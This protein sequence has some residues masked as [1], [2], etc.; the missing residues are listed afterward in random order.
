MIIDNFNF[1]EAT[2]WFSCTALCIAGVRFISRRYY[3][4]FI[5][6]VANIF[7]FGLTDIIEIYTGGF[8]HTAR[9]L[10]VWKIVH[11]LGLVISIIWYIKLRLNSKNI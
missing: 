10:L 1:W 5:F 2:F 7:L 4:W 6:T 11:V 9:W 3:S 8:I